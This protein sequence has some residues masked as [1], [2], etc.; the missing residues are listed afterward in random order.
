[1]D[2]GADAHAV[3]LFQFVDPPN[4]PVGIAVGE[5]LLNVIER[6]AVQPAAQVARV[7]ERDPNSFLARRI[8]ESHPELVPV[9]VQ[10][11][12]LADRGDTGLQHL[13]E[14]EP[15]V[16]EVV[17]RLPVRIAVH[18][19]SPFPEIAAT[20][21]DLTPQQALERVAVH[22]GETRNCPTLE[23]HRVVRNTRH[24]LGDRCDATGCDFEQNVFRAVAEP[25]LLGVP[26]TRPVH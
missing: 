4:P 5:R 14:H 12:E 2:G 19:L 22:V 26:A 11:M 15:R 20:R 25:R 9:T 8:D 23:R 13:A 17:G 21:L 10:V 3:C 6:P 16:V 18:A 1:M 24:A 7:D